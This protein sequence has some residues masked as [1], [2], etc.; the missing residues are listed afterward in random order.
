MNPHDFR[1]PSLPVYLMAGGFSLGLFHAE[2]SGDARDAVDLGTSSH[3]YYRVAS[4]AAVPKVLFAIGSVLALG[5]IGTI[6]YLLTG[7]ALMLWL[8][9]VIATLGAASFAA[10]S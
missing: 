1:K 5:L 2:L 9:P 8:V 7:E 10:F 4:A 6:G 3:P